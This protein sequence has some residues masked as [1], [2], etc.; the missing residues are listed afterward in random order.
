MLSATI[1]EELK[2][3]LATMPISE[4]QRVLEFAR[5]LTDAR[6]RGVTG[7]SLL[8]IAGSIP[9]DDLEQMRAAIE[10]EWPPQ[11]IGDLSSEEFKSV[12]DEV[13]S[14]V[15]AGAGMHR[16]QPGYVYTRQDYYDDGAS[17]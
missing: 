12:A 8:A 15:I 6:P 13:A 14:I 5:T 16:A 11:P 17:R 3:H 2:H 4:Q 9:P 7:S 1:E 10:S